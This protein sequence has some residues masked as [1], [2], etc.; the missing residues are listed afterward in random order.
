MPDAILEPPS[1]V[2]VVV[3]ETTD[4]AVEAAQNGVEA[5]PADVA[6]D[7][8][9]ET[10]DLDASNTVQTNQVGMDWTNPAFMMQMQNMQNMQGMPFGG[11]P[12]MM[13]KSKCTT[14]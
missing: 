2:D 7:A 13:G 5:L 12:N 1:N 8:D 9:K 3:A 14:L 6:G 10:Q 4:N 11:F